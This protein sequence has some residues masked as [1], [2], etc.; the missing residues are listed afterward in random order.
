MVFSEAWYKSI[1]QI[2]Q[3]T[4]EWYVVLIVQNHAGLFNK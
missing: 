3:V 2:L 4:V 1:E